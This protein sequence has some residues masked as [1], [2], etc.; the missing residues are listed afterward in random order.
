M[1]GFANAPSLPSLVPAH[2]PGL[3]TEHENLTASILF[4]YDSKVLNHLNLF[5]KNKIHD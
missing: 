2:L 5:K 4:C 1:T 3:E